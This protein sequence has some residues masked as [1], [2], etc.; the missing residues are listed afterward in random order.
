MAKGNRKV[1]YVNEQKNRVIF[2][3]PNFTQTPN[4]LF[5]L[6]MRDMGE[7]ELKVVLC[8]IRKTYGYHK[9]K[10]AISLTQIQEMTGLSR[11]GAVN[12]VDAAINRGVLE[13]AGTYKG[14]TVYQLVNPVDQSTELTKTSQLSRPQLV[15]PVDTQKKEPKEKKENTSPE[16]DEMLS[17]VRKE[18]KQ[19]GATSKKIAK[20]LLGVCNGNDKDLN[21][22]RPVTAKD[23]LSFV[24]WWDENHKDKQGKTL[25]RP[26]NIGSIKTWV[27]TWLEESKPKQAVQVAPTKPSSSMNAARA[28]A[29]LNQASY[30]DGKNGND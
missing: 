9:S 29:M 24:V 19:Y 10:D 14:I 20:M 8:V 22:S 21:I 12:G 7:A 28:M 2:D 1:D 30:E 16:M 17:L 23:F 18:L 27:E 25:T 3:R 26:K 13:K 4:M 15:N 5:D 11:Q 6:V